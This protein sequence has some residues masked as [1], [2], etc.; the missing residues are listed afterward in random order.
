MIVVAWNNGKYFSSG[1]GYGIKL[2]ETDIVEF[3]NKEWPFILLRLEGEES[4]P[5]KI[6]INK[7]S[8][9]NHTCREL[10]S[11]DIGSWMIKNKVAPWQKGNPPKL[12]LVHISDNIFELQKLSHKE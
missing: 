2:S 3:F 6:N 5:I 8:F 11:K 4:T 7:K 1:A 12:N 9:W 10:I